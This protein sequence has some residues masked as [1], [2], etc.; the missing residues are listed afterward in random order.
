MIDPLRTARAEVAALPAVAAITDRVRRGDPAPG[1]IQ[2]SGKYLAYV[3]LVRLD[4]S[5]D[6]RAPVMEVPITARCYG[7]TRQQAADLWAAISEG[8]NN[9][10]PRIRDGVLVHRS[11]APSDSGDDQDPDTKQP[12]IAGLIR[13]HLATSAVA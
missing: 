13:Y 2:Q 7:T 1:D 10:G 6:L 9:R 12:M 11:F 3:V 5:R 8:L 4:A